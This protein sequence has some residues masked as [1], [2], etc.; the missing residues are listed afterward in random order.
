M[1]YNSKRQLVQTTLFGIPL[2]VHL[3]T[4]N[5]DSPANKIDIS[6]DRAGSIKEVGLQ[7]RAA[8]L[9]QSPISEAVQ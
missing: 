3:T 5:V 6:R 2:S 7:L 1:N 8:T 9:N 4:S